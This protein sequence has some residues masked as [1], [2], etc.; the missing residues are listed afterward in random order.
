MSSDADARGGM[1]IKERMA[2]LQAASGPKEGPTDAAAGKPPPASRAKSFSAGAEVHSGW[3]KRSGTGILS[4]IFYRRCCVLHADPLLVFYEDEARQKY[5]PPHAALPCD[6]S[7]ELVDGVLAI[8]IP[9]TATAKA[10]TVRLSAAEGVETLE[11]WER[12]IEDALRAAYPQRPAVLQEQK[13]QRKAS[14]AA[15]GRRWSVAKAVEGLF[16][17]APSADVS[18]SKAPEPVAP[19][20]EDAPVAPPMTRQ[21]LSFASATRAL[22]AEA[23]PSGLDATVSERVSIAMSAELGGEAGD[24][25]VDDGREAGG[26]VATEGPHEL[27]SLTDDED[28][29]AEP[30]AAAVAAVAAAAVA[31]VAANAKEASRTPAAPQRKP[32]LIDMIVGVF[33]PK[34]KVD[35]TAEPAAETPAEPAAAPPAEPAAATPAAPAA[36]TPAEEAPRTPTA[37][38]RKPSLVDMIVGVFTP[39]PKHALPSGGLEQLGQI[40]GRLHKLA[41][42]D[43]P[44][45]S[46][47]FSSD[48]AEVARL[49]TLVTAVEASYSLLA[50]EN[51]ASGR[52][53]VPRSRPPG[54]DAQA[55][56]AG[57]QA[58]A[59]PGAPSV[60][61]CG[62][63][64]QLGQ[65]AG[66]LHKLAAPD[67]PPIPAHLGSDV[68]D[69][70]RLERLV[71]SVEQS[72]SKLAEA[73]CAPPA[74]PA[75]GTPAK[76]RRRS[77]G[78]GGFLAGV[79]D[80][81]GKSLG[82]G[83]ARVPKEKLPN[84][85]LEELSQIAGRLHKL[86]TPD[87]PPFAA[88]FGPGVA[89]VTRL[90][91]LVSA[92]EHSSSQL[93]QARAAINRG[94]AAGAPLPDPLAAQ[95]G[96]PIEAVAPVHAAS[97]CEV[98]A[99]GGGG[100]GSQLEQLSAIAERLHA[101]A[102]P[103]AP[104]LSAYLVLDVAEEALLEQLVA[105]VECSH[106]QLSERYCAQRGKLRRPTRV[107]RRSC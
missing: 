42:P 100:L 9:A 107:D 21:P 11:D 102:A 65:I 62:G 36:A 4:N 32:S 93:A 6:T 60:L 25:A 52:G 101:L 61:P 98:C 57:V 44:P 15:D 99:G 104:P 66:R 46:A 12:R 106:A 43:A 105:S 55:K 56:P 38:Q 74:A 47:E 13:L 17:G 72:C 68:N 30:G 34:P 75:A 78:V 64:E 48:V 37:P 18:Q 91:A 95:R 89:E 92:V 2:A 58:T 85:G 45:L 20:A 23:T 54:A 33:T 59:V 27:E 41:A 80:S 51:A 53:A 73:R 10:A 81:V 86:A 3:I 8:T 16:G 69:F 67:A 50:Q 83:K 87:A 49:E 40:A 39:K 7:L 14:T 29:E 63:I 97:A 26:E 31:A 90:E 1:S 103:N 96:A 70:A 19:P 24:A 35:A 5:K 77:S 28:A 76:P 94:D 88:H 82:Q 84:G 71:S 22:E 79:A